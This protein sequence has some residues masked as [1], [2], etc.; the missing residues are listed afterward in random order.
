MG[1]NVGRP[2]DDLQEAV[3]SFYLLKIWGLNLDHTCV[4][5]AP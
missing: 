3:L 1:V 2:W 5:Q 4:L